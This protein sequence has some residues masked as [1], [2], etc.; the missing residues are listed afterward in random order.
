M[1]I[2]IYFI[3]ASFARLTRGRHPSAHLQL[4]IRRDWTP[5]FHASFLS[6]RATEIEWILSLYS[7]R[8]MKGT[9]DHPR[10]NDDSHGD[11]KCLEF[12]ASAP[13]DSE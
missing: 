3:V 4:T 7:V 6:V 13:N 9:H 10:C 5:S 8:T 1:Q 11:C 12:M 2:T